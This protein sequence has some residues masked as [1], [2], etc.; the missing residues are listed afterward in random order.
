MGK[1]HSNRRGG[2]GTQSTMKKK[3]FD[4]V[5]SDVLCD[6]VGHDVMKFLYNRR[7]RNSSGDVPRIYTE[8]S[9]QYK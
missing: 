9:A 5:N 8:S 7:K 6:A 3:Q 1:E 2:K 4:A